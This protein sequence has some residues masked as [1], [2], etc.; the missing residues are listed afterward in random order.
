LTRL[1]KKGIGCKIG[2]SL[3]LHKAVYAP[4]LPSHIS[5]AE[6]GNLDF[7]T[8]LDN[9]S[10]FS[11]MDAMRYNEQQE[12]KQQGSAFNGREYRSAR[13]RGY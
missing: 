8:V 7:A 2:L 4:E 5:A 9:T 11:I 3:S 1:G 13:Y 12:I 6:G 10:I